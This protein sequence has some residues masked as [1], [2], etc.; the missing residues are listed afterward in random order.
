MFRINNGQLVE[1]DYFPN[2]STENLMLQFVRFIEGR[3]WIKRNLTKFEA[4]DSEAYQKL[5]Y[6]YNDP[7]LVAL[8]E[9][10]CNQRPVSRAAMSTLFYY[11][12][13]LN[14]NE[15]FAFEKYRDIVNQWD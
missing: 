9:K 7:L 14:G 4:L 13:A 8:Y 5:M 6:R 1:T 3:E 10:I 11:T 2:I 12:I 15:D